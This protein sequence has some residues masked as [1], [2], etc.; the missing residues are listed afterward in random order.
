MV[1]HHG[2]GPDEVDQRPTGAGHLQDHVSQPGE[3]QQVVPVGGGV[4]ASPGRPPPPPEA[5]RSSR[6]GRGRE[7]LALRGPAQLA[8]EAQQRRQVQLVRRVVK[9]PGG[10]RI[11]LVVTQEMGANTAG[12]TGGDRQRRPRHSG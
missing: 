4:G 5:G 1:A 7:Q 8:Q 2:P 11:S 12:I 3:Q 6:R 9:Q 10:G